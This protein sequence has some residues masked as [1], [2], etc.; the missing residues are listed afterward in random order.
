MKTL[1]SLVCLVILTALAAQTIVADIAKP[2]SPPQS[3]KVV[4]QRKLEVV[5]DGKVWQARLQISQ[6]DLQELRAALDGGGSNTAAV[7]SV[8]QSPVRTIIAGVLLFLSVSF[9]GVWLARSARNSSANRGR[10]A[11]AAGVLIV[12]VLGAAAIITRGNAGPPP[13][14]LNW[15]RLSKNFAQGRTTS[16]DFVIEVV[17]DQPNTPPG[18]KLLVP[19]NPKQTGD[20][21]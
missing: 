4:L 13:S 11:I 8:A 10:K 3:T 1:L 16:G 19:Y 9:A 15:T 7:F 18:V 21:E 14:Y 6:S 2:K 20:D 12:A 5:P 17:P